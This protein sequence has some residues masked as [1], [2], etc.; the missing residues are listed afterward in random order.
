LDDSKTYEAILEERLDVMERHMALHIQE[1]KLLTKQIVLLKDR[2]QKTSFSKA[3]DQQQVE[4]G[5]STK[6]LVNLHDFDII[7]IELVQ[8]SVFA[9]LRSKLMLIPK[10][11]LDALDRANPTTAEQDE[12]MSKY[13]GPK[14]AKRNSAYIQ[15]SRQLLDVMAS[16]GAYS[17]VA[18]EIR[19][20]V[21]P[22]PCG[23]K[24]DGF[25]QYASMPAS[26]WATETRQNGCLNDALVDLPPVQP[27]L[28][29]L[30]TS[31]GNLM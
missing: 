31:S 24:L 27:V 8:S 11:V 23:P 15:V 2:L 5:P 22:S 10:S 16:N 30:E 20:K 12:I 17:K 28:M 25:A 6:Q 29:E 19:G 1:R 9:I 4:A 14:P 7:L 21:F 18:L 26:P 3:N 13:P